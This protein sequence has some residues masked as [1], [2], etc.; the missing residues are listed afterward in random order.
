MPLKLTGC[1][2][3]YETLTCTELLGKVIEWKQ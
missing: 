1:K 2:V 3:Q